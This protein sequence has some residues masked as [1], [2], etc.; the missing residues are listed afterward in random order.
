MV[1]DLKDRSTWDLV[2]PSWQLNSNSTIHNLFILGN[3][4]HVS[5]YVEGYVVLDISDPT[6]PTLA[7]QY[8]TYDGLDGPFKVV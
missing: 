8:D 6:N 4:A 1:W 3:Y 7:G 2:V 5:Y